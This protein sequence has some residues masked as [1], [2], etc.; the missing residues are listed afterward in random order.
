M[1]TKEE[2]QKIFEEIKADPENAKYTE[3]GIDPLY[4]ITPEAKILIVGQAPGKRAQDTRVFW[5]DPSGDNL[6]QW[7]GVDR[8]TFYNSKKFAILP[9]D[10][11]YPGKGRSGDLPPRKDFAAKWHKHLLQYAPKIELTLLVGSYATKHYLGLKSQAKL[12][13]IVRDYKAYLPEYFPLVHPSPRNK[14]WQSK[15]P[16]FQAEVLPDLKERV[17]KILED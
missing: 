15:N 5:N 11:Y 13:D 16:W 2:L 7:M 4:E 14:I 6:R 12:T 1:S 8:D 10:F 9:M 17:H 3:Q